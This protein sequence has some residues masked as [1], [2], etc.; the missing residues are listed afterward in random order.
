[1]RHS[2]ASL[3]PL[4]V[5]LSSCGASDI[6]DDGGITDPGEYSL[7]EDRTSD[8]SI[9][10]TI[11]SDGVVLDLQGNTISCGGDPATSQATGIQIN[12]EGLTVRN[13]KITGCF[14]GGQVRNENGDVT[15]ERIDFTGN[16][17]IGVNGGKTFVGNTFDGISGY[18][19]EPYAIGINYPSDDCFI[20]RNTFRNLHRQPV[21]D[22]AM[23]GEG[24]GVLVPASSNG[25]IIEANWFEND[26][27]GPERDIGVWV[28]AGGSATIRENSFTNL[29]WAVASPG[30]ASVTDNRFWMRDT[31]PG[32]V[33]IAARDKAK[34]DASGNV[35]IGFEK[36]FE[37]PLKQTK[38]LIL[39]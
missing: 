29:G 6:P 21:S 25:C 9:V 4:S 12:G 19:V 33:A 20:S 28:A 37:G 23:I 2:L 31:E 30:T 26:E 24:V 34:V 14:M 5:L 36:P 16:T 15:W 32:S 11:D 10:I 13:G 27:L 39:P 22:Q 35:V 7:T 1:M 18:E 8:Q 3:L 17:Y 38:N